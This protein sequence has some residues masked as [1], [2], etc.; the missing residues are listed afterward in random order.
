MKTREL[1]H[2]AIASILLRRGDASP[3]GDTDSLVLSGRIDSIGVMEIA[4]L[5][6]QTFGVDFA[7]RGFDPA[8]IDS[9]SSI[10]SLIVGAGRAPSMD[11]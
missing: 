6:E 2:E 4:G 9:V 8:E 11:A 10:V 3:L 1:V 7:R 5:L